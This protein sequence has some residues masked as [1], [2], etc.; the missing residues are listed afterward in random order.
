[1]NWII[2]IIATLVLGAGTA[3]A[4]PHVFPKDPEHEAYREEYNTRPA[5]RLIRPLTEG[6]TEVA[7]R[8]DAQPAD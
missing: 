6:L 8:L 1:M 7:R 2:R 3:Y 5:L 4:A